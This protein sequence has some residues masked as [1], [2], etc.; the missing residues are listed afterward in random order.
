[1]MWNI[2]QVFLS[3][4]QVFSK[5]NPT[6]VSV[7]RNMS[8]H[9]SN[10]SWVWFIVFV[11]LLFLHC[12]PPFSKEREK[13]HKR[14]RQVGLSIKIL[15]PKLFTEQFRNIH[16]TGLE[17][18][19]GLSVCGACYSLLRLCYPYTARSSLCL[20][21]LCITFG[22]FSLSWLYRWQWGETKYG[23]QQ[24]THWPVQLMDPGLFLHW[25]KRK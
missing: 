1:M 15:Q 20:L 2:F 13:K 8:L 10:I 23:Y 4:F 19:G 17:H 22:H 21:A 5:C 18:C 7:Y 25:P 9:L 24:D 11:S 3:L 6:T 12:F 16:F 14:K